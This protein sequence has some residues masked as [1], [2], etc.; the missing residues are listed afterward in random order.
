M[1]IAHPPHIYDKMVA[2]SSSY[3]LDAHSTE[4]QS[5]LYGGFT[6]FLTSLLP[7]ASA[8]EAKDEPETASSE[9]DDSKDKEEESSDGDA[10]EGGDDAEEAE[11]E[12]EEEEE[13]PEDEAPAIREKCAESKEC[14]NVKHHFDHCQE[15]V[16][17]GKGHKGEDCV[18][19]LFHLMHC[20]DTC[21]APKIFA[22]LR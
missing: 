18:E 3:E 12:E 14:V 4:Q 22:K 6:S 15:R 16:E 1:G 17:A 9:E 19:E 5:S 8:D 20:V 10:E 7:S 2:S 13:E 11:E 21:A